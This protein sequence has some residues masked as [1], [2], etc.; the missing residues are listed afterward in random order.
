MGER[1]NAKGSLV[2]N[3]K[4][5]HRKITFKD[6]SWTHLAQDMV[7]WWALVNLVMNLGYH[8]WREIS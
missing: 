5:N 1:R 4:E 7:L 2:K 6:T 8:E 3:P